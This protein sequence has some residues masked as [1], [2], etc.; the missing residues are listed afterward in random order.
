[1]DNEKTFDEITEESAIR[2][3]DK[4]AFTHVILTDDAP[5]PDVM[6]RLRQVYPRI[7]HLDWDNARTR[8]ADDFSVT[9][10]ASKHT[11]SSLFQEFF[12]QMNGA[13]MTDEQARYVD[14]LIRAIW[15]DNA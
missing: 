2:Q 7:T 6:N 14:G 1:M 12:Q 3:A 15:E 9:A 10:D 5:I 13:E 11:P 8:A 4:G